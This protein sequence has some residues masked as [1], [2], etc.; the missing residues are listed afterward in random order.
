MK[1]NPE[2]IAM[3]NSRLAEE[4]TAIVQYVTHAAMCENWGYAKL[5]GYLNGRAQEEMKHVSMV[6]DRILFLDGLPN[7]PALGDVHTGDTVEAMFEM[8]HAAEVI[9]IAGYTEGVDVALQFKDYGTRDLM[10]KLILEE[11]RH[12]NDIEAAMAQ[13]A[14]MGIGN[15]LPAQIEG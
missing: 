3:L 13:I 8:D 15:Y 9:A 11:D 14:Q 1:G 12:L 5:A 10:E 6:M 2:V 4:H 7:L